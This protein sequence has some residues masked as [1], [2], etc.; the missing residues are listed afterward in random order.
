[1]LELNKA[2]ETRGKLFNASEISNLGNGVYGGV[3]NC[4][5]KLSPRGQI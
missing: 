4:K 1:M 5:Y 2:T 3:N